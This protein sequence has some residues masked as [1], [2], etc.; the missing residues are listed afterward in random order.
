[1]PSRRHQRDSSRLKTTR[2]RVQPRLTQAEARELEGRAAADFRSVGNYVAWLIAQ[3][4][5]AKR[6]A[7][8]RTKAKPGDKRAG[9][10]I[11]V[12]ITIPDRRELEKRAREEMRSLSSYVAKLI[13]EDLAK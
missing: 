11:N 9:Y 8:S 5:S 1:M 3:N 10:S 13:V 12:P 4:L 2:L 6:K 7:R